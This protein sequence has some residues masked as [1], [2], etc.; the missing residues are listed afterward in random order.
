MGGRRKKNPE[1]GE[2]VE[3]QPDGTWKKLTDAVDAGVGAIGDALMSTGPAQSIARSVTADLP[4]RPSDAFLEDLKQQAMRKAPATGHAPLRDMPAGSEPYDEAQ[5][6]STERIPVSRTRS[7]KD[8]HTEFRRPLGERLFDAAVPQA[9]GV[10]EGLN[11]LS[12]G[13]SSI[14]A[15][16]LYPEGQAQLE[17][18]AARSPVTPIVSAAATLAP[19][20]LASRVGGAAAGAVPEFF[21]AAQGLRG[22]AAKAL[23]GAGRAIAAGAATGA[24]RGAS[25]GVQELQRGA[26]PGEAA[27]LVPEAML[28]DV[29]ASLAMYPLFSAIQH[30]GARSVRALR[31]SPDMGPEVVANELVGHTT[32]VPVFGLRRAIQTEVGQRSV[33]GRLPF[34][35][36][37]LPAPEG[38]VIAEAQRQQAQTGEPASD[39]TARKGAKPV[40]ERLE[41][42]RNEV[43]NRQNERRTMYDESPQGQEMIPLDP[44]AQR[45]GELAGDVTGGGGRPLVGAIPASSKLHNRLA[46]VYEYHPAQPGEPGI[47]LEEAQ[48]LGIPPAQVSLRQSPP[49]KNMEF[50]ADQEAFDAGRKDIMKPLERG[51]GYAVRGGSQPATPAARRRAAARQR[52]V[53]TADTAPPES[54]AA[55]ATRAIPPPSNGETGGE[56]V[57]LRPRAVNFR[58]LEKS[59]ALLDDAANV[60]ANVEGKEVAGYDKQIADAFRGMRQRFGPNEVAR[61]DNEQTLSTGEKVTGPAAMMQEHANELAALDNEFKALGVDPKID[62]IDPNNIELARSVA[63]SIRGGDGA[64]NALGI[65]DPA[66]RQAIRIASAHQALD[67]LY[68]RTPAPHA[69]VTQSGPHAIGVL[70]N[71]RLMLD[72]FARAAAGYLAPQ[73]GSGLPPLN[74]PG[75]SGSR[76]ARAAQV[77]APETV[78]KFLAMIGLGATEDDQR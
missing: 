3:Q 9:V 42:K 40:I 47:S 18:M 23:T 41:S 37:K 54:E 20:S 50:E 71:L 64:L 1:T 16:Q 29:P 76:S 30:G 34:T 8:E 55:P 35:R 48:K 67:R 5:R 33:P 60:G 65:T 53:E 14:P 78:N 19:M 46:E 38:D 44:V 15:R 58:Q 72:P 62:R 70:G 77:V 25:E 22:V 24:V 36:A 75:L 61:A 49:P 57:V 2:V 28:Q 17:Q 12:F 13:A 43:R 66:E 63:R 69:I 56:R 26:T 45:I 73:S 31:E 27:R 59:R 74:A 32:Q 39:I 68:S 21:P 51:E 4:K 52:V 6:A 7:G 11:S 10:L